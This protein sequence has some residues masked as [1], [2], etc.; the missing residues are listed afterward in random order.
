MKEYTVRVP[1]NQSDFF[2]ELLA[3]LGFHEVS[4]GNLE[5]TERQQNLILNRISNAKKDEMLDWETVQD[6]FVFAK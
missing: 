4:E 5:A 6:D 3:K 1:E 2:L